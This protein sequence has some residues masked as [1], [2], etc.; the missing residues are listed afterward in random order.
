MVVVPLEA[1]VVAVENTALVVWVQPQSTTLQPKLSTLMVLCWGKTL[2][3]ARN[4]AADAGVLVPGA[5]AAAASDAQACG[6]LQA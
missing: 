3:Q 6:Q 5:P 4:A 2:R 1:A